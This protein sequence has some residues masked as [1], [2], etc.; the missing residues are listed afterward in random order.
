MQS[1]SQGQ[2][3][4]LLAAL[5][6]AEQERDQLAQ[7]HAQQH[8]HPQLLSSAASPRHSWQQQLQPRY[9]PSGSPLRAAQSWEPGT[10]QAEAAAARRDAEAACAALAAARQENGRLDEE[11]E[12]LRRWG[13]G[14]V[15]HP[16]ALPVAECWGLGVWM[17]AG[18]CCRASALH[19]LGR[20]HSKAA[21]AF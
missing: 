3:A 20:S 19:L 7:L 4:D 9:G 10:Q 6:R 1:R 21:S 8:A 14:C 16:G 11:L 18:G 15:L 13:A 5:Q 17:G 12:L 2:H